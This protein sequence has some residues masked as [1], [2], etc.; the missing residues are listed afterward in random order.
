[1]EQL[2][3]AVKGIAGTRVT[4]APRDAV[5][6]AVGGEI[7]VVDP[8]IDV[9]DI[10]V[11]G[12]RRGIDV[13]RLEPGGRGLEQLA[14]ALAARRDLGVVHLLCRG[15]PGAL[16][17]AGERLDLPALVMRRGVLVEMSGAFRPGA[18][19]V[20]YGGSV[21]CG[22]AGLQFLDYLEAALG[23]TVAASATPVGAAALGGRW[24]LRDRC[25]KPVPTAFSALSRATY[26]ALLGGPR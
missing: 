19:L 1:M 12:R 15:E 25:G 20:L 23:L 24:T 9:P 5:A 7:L 10:L 3:A 4:A 11:N 2:R 22:P 16:V 14:D 8:G 18:A 13:H 21:A 6:A 17:L 26:P